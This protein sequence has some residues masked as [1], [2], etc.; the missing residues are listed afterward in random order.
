MLS[1][2][3]VFIGF[4]SYSAADLET[5]SYPW[6]QCCKNFSAFVFFSPASYVG[7]E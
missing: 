4:N 2:T 3:L 5:L 6:P 1:W 7:W